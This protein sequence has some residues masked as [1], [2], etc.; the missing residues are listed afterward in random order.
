MSKQKYL[1][2]KLVKKSLKE[3]LIES[4]G[5]SEQDAKSKKIWYVQLWNDEYSAV[6]FLE[7]FEEFIT[8]NLGVQNINSF[9]KKDEYGDVNDFLYNATNN[10]ELIEYFYKVMMDN[11]QIPTQLIYIKNWVKENIIE[12][13]SWNWWVYYVLGLFLFVLFTMI[14]ISPPADALVALLGIDTFYS[15][16]FEWGLLFIYIGLPIYINQKNKE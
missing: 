15:G 2:K 16:V 5:I 13:N 4:F 3:V 8:D 7:F 9:N 12:L 1:N 11:Y 10:A 14:F 6:F